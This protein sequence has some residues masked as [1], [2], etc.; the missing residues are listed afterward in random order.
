MTTA[1]PID[2]VVLEAFRL[3]LPDP[4]KY[5]HAPSRLMQLY[6][7]HRLR[8]ALRAQQPALRWRNPTMMKH[9]ERS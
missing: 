6:I 3:S 4:E 7:G 1:A 5:R 8:P 2:A 9:T